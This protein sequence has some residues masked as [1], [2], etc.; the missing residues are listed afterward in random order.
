MLDKILLS[1]ESPAPARCAVCDAFET[2]DH[3][4]DF[5][6]RGTPDPRGCHRLYLARR[7]LMNDRAKR[8]CEK[9]AVDWRARA[10]KAEAA[11][12]ALFEETV[13][14]K[15]VIARHHRKATSPR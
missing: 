12:L 4:D 9:H 8:D 13:H 6:G 11:A 5:R 1:G 3:P 15:K 2:E 10:H 14:L 7:G